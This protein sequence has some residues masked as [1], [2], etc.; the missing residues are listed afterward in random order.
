[1]LEFSSL[2]KDPLF[3]TKYRLTDFMCKKGSLAILKVCV[4]AG[5]G[6]RAREPAENLIYTFDSDVSS[7][8]KDLISVGEV[9]NNTFLSTN[10]LKAK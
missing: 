10:Q 3:L 5:A 4:L 1:M 6:G 2:Q 7:V 8:F 9:T